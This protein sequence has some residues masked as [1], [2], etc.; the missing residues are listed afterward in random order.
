MTGPIENWRSD[1]AGVLWPP[2]LEGTGALVLAAVARLAETQW[3]PPADIA[4]QQRRQLAVLADHCARHS[5]N[6]ATRLSQ[7]E[8]TPADLAQPGGLER[9]APLTRRALQAG[10]GVFCSDIPPSHRPVAINQTSGSTGEP[11]VVRRTALNHLGSMAVTVRDHQWQ[12][13]DAGLRLA[14]MSA[15]NHAVKQVPDWGPPLGLLYRTGPALLLPSAI[16]VGELLTIL[17]RF[18]PQILVI[19][20]SMLTALIGEIERSG[21]RLDGLRHLRCMSEMVHPE[22]RARNKA[23][24]GLDLEDA[25]SSEECGFIA[26]QCPDGEGYHVMAETHLVEI[27]DGTGRPCAP[28]ETGRVLVTDLH[29]FATPLI[30]YDIGDYAVAG[31]VCPCG[32]GL[33]RIDR[34]MGR[35]R[36]L[37]C[38]PDGT[39]YWPLVGYTRYRAIA[40]VQQYQLVQHD[41]HRVEARLVVE[42]PLTGAEEAALAEAIQGGLGYPFA[43][44]FSYH[45]DRLTAGPSGKSEELVSLVDPTHLS[46]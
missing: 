13:R 34:I 19:Y 14:A 12:K 39:R 22:L 33:P 2:V 11:V 29:N 28:G 20:P 5:P 15:H 1:L 4:H 46:H 24:F 35:E 23:I 25:Y 36:N 16:D 43:I 3:L 41:L 26:L 32:R 30:R 17:T 45:R 31:G 27:V 9:L 42:R 8:L 7:A 40:P 6:F 10:S 37:I 44:S 21:T 38:L 18:D